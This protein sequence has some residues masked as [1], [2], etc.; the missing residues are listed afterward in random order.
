MNGR[1]RGQHSIKLFVST[2]MKT[3]LAALAAELDRPLAEVCRTL[4]AMGLPILEGAEAARRSGVEFILNEDPD[5][6]PSASTG[7]PTSVPRP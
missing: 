6:P 5:A 2:E 1:L 3:R 4:M 7:G